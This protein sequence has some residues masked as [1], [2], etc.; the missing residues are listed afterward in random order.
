MLKTLVLT[1]TDIFLSAMIRLFLVFTYKVHVLVMAVSF[2][3]EYFKLV[4]YLILLTRIRPQV[5]LPLVALPLV[6]CMVK[7][8]FVSVTFLVCIIPLLA[9]SL[10]IKRNSSE[11]LFEPT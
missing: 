10:F 4:V 7:Q 9:I 11:I 3:Q 8:C 2:K 5:H 6:G 1:V